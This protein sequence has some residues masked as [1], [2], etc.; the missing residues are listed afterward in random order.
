MFRA[1]IIG[2]GKM[3]LS[4]QSMVNVHPQI[5]LASVSDSSGYDLDVLSKYTGVKTYT[6]YKKMLA[7]EPLDCVF[8]ARGPRL[9]LPISAE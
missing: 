4:H 8:V 6:D 5:K 1:A 9:C 7:E 2:L 3:G